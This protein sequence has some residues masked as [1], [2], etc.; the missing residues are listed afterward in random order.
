MF[1][2]PI[3]Y[4]PLAPHTIQCFRIVCT[5]F[6]PD[7]F[8]LVCIKRF[9]TLI[10]NTIRDD[11]KNRKKTNSIWLPNFGFASNMPAIVVIYP[12][13][14]PMFSM[15]KA[16]FPSNHRPTYQMAFYCA[17]FVCG[18]IFCCCCHTYRYTQCRWNELYARQH[19]TTLTF[20]HMNNGVV[21]RPS[22]THAH[23]YNLNIHLRHLSITGEHHWAPAHGTNPS[24]RI[25]IGSPVRITTNANE[26]GIKCAR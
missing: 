24:K 1:D 2:S 19:M 17:H 7:Q 20:V 4:R 23:T 12:R 18:W 5:Y 11:M 13:L 16:H 21:L 14:Y 22:K 25:G 26:S 10:S 15:W 8:A 3:L 6:W 9:G